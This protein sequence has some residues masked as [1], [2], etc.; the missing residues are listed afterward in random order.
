M[1]Y[2]ADERETILQIDDVSK[3]WSVYTRQRTMINKLIK[4]GYEPFNVEMEDDTI[5]SCEFHLDL[6][7]IS[8]KKAIVNKREYTDDE[9]KAIRDRLQKG[10][11]NIGTDSIQI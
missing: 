7:K 9:K 4:L 11:Q 2:S 6:N 3:V 5:V 1:A 10:K 8:F